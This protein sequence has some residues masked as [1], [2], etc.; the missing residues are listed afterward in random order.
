ML[1]STLNTLLCKTFV[2]SSLPTSSP[3]HRPCR[4]VLLHIYIDDEQTYILTWLKKTYYYCYHYHNRQLNSTQQPNNYCWYATKQPTT[5]S[6]VVP[7]TVPLLLL[8]QCS[9]MCT[10][11]CNFVCL[12]L[13]R[14]LFTPNL[15]VIRQQLLAT[16]PTPPLQPL[17]NNISLSSEQNGNKICNILLC[18]AFCFVCLIM[19]MMALKMDVKAVGSFYYE[20]FVSI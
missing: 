20:N 11:I 14:I 10:Y 16:S 12:H 9:P 8:L 5:N 15:L 3:P 7:P 17:T 6:R 2:I 18:I 13:S 1:W 19:M 4:L